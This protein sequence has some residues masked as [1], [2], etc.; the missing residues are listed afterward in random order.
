MDILIYCLIFVIGALTGFFISKKSFS[1]NFDKLSELVKKEFTYAASKQISEEQKEI[2]EQNQSAVKLTLEPLNKQIEDFKKE[3]NNY[4][5]IHTKNTGEITQKL[6]DLTQKS[7]MLSET[8]QNL[9]D[10]LTQNRNVKGWYGEDLAKTI[11]E[12]SGFK[13][14]IHFSCQSVEVIEDSNKTVRPDFEIYLPDNRNIVIDSKAILSSIVDYND[15][16]DSIKYVFSFWSGSF[17]AFTISSSGASS[18]FS[19]E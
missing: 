2:L 1:N 12:N 6:S 3:I 10:A 19:P 4:R 16:E 17:I 8:A 9:S 5:D 15:T 13:E 18:T 14:G 11:L 7:V